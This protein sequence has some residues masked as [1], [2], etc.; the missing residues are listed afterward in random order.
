MRGVVSIVQ[1]LGRRGMT[2]SVT[3]ADPLAA[4]RADHERIFA[5]RRAAR[6]DRRRAGE[7]AAEAAKSHRKPDPIMRDRDLFVGGRR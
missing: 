3:A 4:L 6:A 1:R 2:E 7:A 5:E